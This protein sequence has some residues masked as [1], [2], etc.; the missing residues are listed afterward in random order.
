[1]A[2]NVDPHFVDFCESYIQ[3][4]IC[5]IFKKNTVIGRL[6]VA[7]VPFVYVQY[8]TIDFIVA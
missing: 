1:M 4:H 2:T 8:N 6:I 3:Y 5:S 7:V